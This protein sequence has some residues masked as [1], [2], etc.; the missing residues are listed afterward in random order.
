MTNGKS[1]CTVCNYI[2]EESAEQFQSEEKSFGRF[3]ELPSDW[4]CPDCGA[5]KEMFQPCSCVALKTADYSGIEKPETEDPNNLIGRTLGQIVTDFPQFACVFEQYGLDYCCGG[6]KLLEQ[7]CDE[8]GVSVNQLLAKLTQS[9]AGTVAAAEPD[10]TQTTLKALIEHIISRYH[11]R[12]QADLP[13][14]TDL[15]EKVAR[16][17][18]RNHP[19]MIEVA[20]I[21]KS[22]REE[23]EQ[24]MQKEELILFPG[25]LG[26]ESGKNARFGCGGSV[27]HPIEMMMREHE[28]A[29]EALAQLSKLTNNYTPPADACNTFKI[30]LHALA[31]LELEMHQHVHKENNILFPRTLKLV[32]T[33]PVCR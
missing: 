4:R 19:E 21:F 7:A 29:G 3:E 17:H 13:R 28:D 10:W 25:I 20:Q 6:Q 23:L 15:V 8:K 11:Q 31:T 1:I 2:Y 24:H 9:Q 33:M 30:L 12:L 16:V 27:D 26:I 32:A 5:D 14:L 18:G 22:L